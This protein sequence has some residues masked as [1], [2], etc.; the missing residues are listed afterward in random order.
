MQGP[1]NF[2]IIHGVFLTFA[3]DF[4]LQY[5]TICR[6][7]QRKN[8]LAKA[9][10]TILYLLFQTQRLFMVPRLETHILRAGSAKRRRRENPLRHAGS[11]QRRIHPRYLCPRH[12]LHAEAGGER[13]GEFPLRRSP[14][15]SAPRSGIQRA[16]AGSKRRS[17]KLPASY[18]SRF[19]SNR[20]SKIRLPEKVQK[21]EQNHGKSTNFR[22][23]GLLAHFRS[24]R[25]IWDRGA[26]AEKRSYI[27][28]EGALE[29]N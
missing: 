5:I 24:P 20:Y 21:N 9:S 12:D 27:L 14:V 2:G 7:S 10:K 29:R 23:F 3:L 25:K 4:N 1:Q 28:G 22:G 13:G 16:R 6:I 26:G 19:G 18:G 8:F 11:L 17:R 15:I